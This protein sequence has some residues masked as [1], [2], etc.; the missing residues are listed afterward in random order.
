MDGKNREVVAPVQGG[1]VDAVYHSLQKM[2]ATNY[3]E[4]NS[5]KL[6]NYKVMIAIPKLELFIIN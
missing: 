1:P 2:I 4:I 3:K 6:I 5:V